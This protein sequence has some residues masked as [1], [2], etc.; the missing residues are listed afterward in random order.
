MKRFIFFLLIFG[1]SYN[2][3]AMF[4]IS[5]SKNS[6]NNA[7]VWRQFIWQQ[8][9]ENTLRL[10]YIKSLQ[11]YVSS[12]DESFTLLHGEAKVLLYDVL[13]VQDVKDELQETVGQLS[14]VQQNLKKSEF[15]V[16]QQEEKIQ[17]LEQQ[18]V[19][20]IQESKNEIAALSFKF[21][22]YVNDAMRVEKNLKSKLALKQFHLTWQQSQVDHCNLINER[23]KKQVV[24][25]QQNAE[26]YKNI[27]VGCGVCAI[28]SVCALY[29]HM[30]S[31]SKY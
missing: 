24:Q 6:S 13:R 12:R 14:D 27:V 1:V 21:Q 26:F 9:T 3:S 31:K 8:Q 29:V 17:V 23:L 15:V 25:A 20:T 18:L 2:I 30:Q 11:R 22:S 4:R 5:F 28:A 16:Q 7:E 10:F 19:D